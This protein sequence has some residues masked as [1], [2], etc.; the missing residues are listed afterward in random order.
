MWRPRWRRQPASP[1]SGAV[2]R[3][4]L[5][6]RAVAG[7]GSLA[8]PGAPGAASRKGRPGQWAAGPARRRAAAGSAHVTSRA[9]LPAGCEHFRVRGARRGA[10]RAEGAERGWPPHGEALLYRPALR[11]GCPSSRLGLARARCPRRL[12][13]PARG[14]PPAPKPCALKPR[15]G[16]GCSCQRPDGA[17]TCTGRWVEPPRRGAGGVR[18][19]PGS[20]AA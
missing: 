17:G 2:V 16:R 5:G 6:R 15:R 12:P 9:S 1:A 20:G 14:A 3:L 13:S 8:S 10:A 11:P 18:V 19:A 7:A 4:G